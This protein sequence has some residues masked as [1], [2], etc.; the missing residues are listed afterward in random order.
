MEILH[1]SVA[2]VT[3]FSDFRL[4]HIHDQRLCQEILHFRY[5]EDSVHWQSHSH[6]N[7]ANR[8]CFSPRLTSWFWYIVPPQSLSSSL[9]FAMQCKHIWCQ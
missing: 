5:D 7:A 8:I 2:F 1:V 6:S 4:H 3:K 9:T